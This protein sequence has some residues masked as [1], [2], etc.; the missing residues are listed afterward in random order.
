MGLYTQDEI[1]LLKKN[2]PRM[3]QSFLDAINGELR[4]R[5]DDSIDWSIEDTNW[6]IKGVNE[7]DL[8]NTSIESKLELSDSIIKK[9]TNEVINN[10]RIIEDELIQPSEIEWTDVLLADAGIV[11]PIIAERDN[12]ELPIVYPNKEYEKGFPPNAED[13][14]LPDPSL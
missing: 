7:I 11:D 5:T 3:L 6:L 1:K 4:R 2:D 14:I 13:R 8:E 10:P 12:T 9:I